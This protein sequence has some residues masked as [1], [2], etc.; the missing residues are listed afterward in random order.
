MNLSLFDIVGDAPLLNPEIVQQV[1]AINSAVEAQASARV[2]KLDA[3]RVAAIEFAT[4]IDQGVK[5]TWDRAAEVMKPLC[6]GTDAEGAWTPQDLYNAAESGLVRTIVSRPLPLDANATIARLD[7]LDALLPPRRRR[8]EEGI[9]L[10]QFSTPSPYAWLAS[11]AARI[12]ANDTVLEPS[13]GTGLLAV[14]AKLAAATLVVNEIDN[15]RLGL[16][17]HLEAASATDHD[18]RYLSALYRGEKPSVC[19]M[20]P[21]FSIDQNLGADRRVRALALSHVDQAVRTVRRGGRVVAIVG[22][23]QSPAIHLDLWDDILARATVRAAIAIDGAAYRHMGTTFSTAIVVLDAI[24]DIQKP[25]LYTSPVSIA[26]AYALLAQVAPRI[27]A[28][29]GAGKHAGG[30]VVNLE[31]IRTRTEAVADFTFV[32]K[33]EPIAYIV[34]DDVDAMR[35]DGRYAHY[36]PQTIQILNAK[37]HPTPLVESAALA[38]VR[39]PVP[40]YVPLLPPSLLATDAL[41][42]AQVEAV[43]YAGNAHEKML[44]IVEEDEE[45]RRASSYVRRGWMSGYGTGVGKGRA[46][47]LDAQI[48]TPDG[49]T[50]MGLIRPGDTVISGAGKPTKVLQIFPQGRVPIFRVTFSDGSSTRCTADHLWSTQTKKQR[51][52]ERHELGIDYP[53]P[54]TLTTRAIGES[55]HL[56]HGIPLVPDV[57]FKPQPVPLDPYPFGALIADACIRS[58]AVEFTNADEEIIYLRL[59][60]TPSRRSTEEDSRVPLLDREDEQPARA[61]AEQCGNQGA[62]RVGAFR[63]TRL[64]EVRSERLQVQLARRAS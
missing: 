1:A 5:L 30:Q 2:V 19:V 49:W 53:K 52:Y 47:P 61:P 54:K 59:K 24:V 11:V 8:S 37:D 33:P 48:L 56:G 51:F 15:D 63:A 50:E 14:F 21:P 35:E 27:G 12:T 32:E 41:S 29:E 43:V 26:E 60:Y 39:P 3:L 7:A 20:N 57:D 9:R 18:A 22:H 46:Q 38:C 34:R 40:T 23:N 62:V 31:A 64:G 44:E 17:D 16:L 10:Q 13:A 45:H 25:L 28:L 6:G 55:V 36:A 42:E 58:H 4:L